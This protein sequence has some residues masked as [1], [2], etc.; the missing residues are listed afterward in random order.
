MG[1]DGTEHGL[2]LYL[3]HG[4]IMPSNV[5]D[6]HG[7]TVA[8]TVVPLLREALS[9]FLNTGFCRSPP[10]CTAPNKLYALAYGVPVSTAY[11]VATVSTVSSV[12][13]LMPPKKSVV[14]QSNPWSLNSNREPAI[15]P[16]IAPYIQRP[17]SRSEAQPLDR[18]Y[19]H[20]AP[21]EDWF[22]IMFYRFSA[23]SYLRRW[24]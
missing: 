9:Q 21:C 11:F 3:F 4:G 6:A 15:S 1:N 17:L 20:S 23:P 14:R 12:Y 7:G 19:L 24:W 13:A 2:L 16:K 10:G 18:L 22:F 5:A 8:V